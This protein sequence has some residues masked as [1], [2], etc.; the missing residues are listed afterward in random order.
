MPKERRIV[1]VARCE[2][3]CV[4]VRA[5][6]RREVVV[7]PEDDLVDHGVLRGGGDVGLGLL[8]R[9]V[10][11]VP[12]QLGAHLA[13]TAREVC[14]LRGELEFTVDLPEGARGQLLG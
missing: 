7:A 10:L 3:V 8:G 5:C 12:P 2:W 4:H 11:A 13:G 1:H 6:L 14:A 9:R